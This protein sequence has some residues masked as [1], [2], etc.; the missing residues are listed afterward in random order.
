[1]V[2]YGPLEETYTAENLAA[3]Y[4]GPVIMLGPVASPPAHTHHTGDHT[5]HHGA[6][7]HTHHVGVGGGG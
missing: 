3:T 6:H 7:E 5:H 4:G 2:S 1:M